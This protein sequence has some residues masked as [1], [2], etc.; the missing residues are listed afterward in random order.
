MLAHLEKREPGEEAYP[1]GL[2]LVLPHVDV[3]RFAGGLGGRRLREERLEQGLLVGERDGVE[4]GH[5]LDHHPE[6]AHVQQ[7]ARVDR[8]KQLLFQVVDH[9]DVPQD[10]ALKKK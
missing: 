2:D 3:V 8:D 7:V 4:L 1:A 10:V 6:V 5:R 9:Q